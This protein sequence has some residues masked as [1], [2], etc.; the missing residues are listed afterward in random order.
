MNDELRENAALREAID[1]AVYRS[2]AKVF[3]ILGVDMSMTQKASV[4]ASFLDCMF[5]MPNEIFNR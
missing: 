2:T 3:A 5:Y 4:S 1:R